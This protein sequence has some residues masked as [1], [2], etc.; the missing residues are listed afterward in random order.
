MFAQL[1]RRY[2][3][4]ERIRTDS[5]QLFASNALGRLSTLSVWWVR[6]AI[7]P[8]PIE[9]AHS[10][11]NG[12]HERMHNTLKAASARPPQAHLAAQQRCCDRFRQ[13]CNDERPHEALG[14]ATPPIC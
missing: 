5:G 2:R 14:D 7:R 6:L 13:R 4:P 12:R 3:L 11:Q 9:P 8:E 10:E 1:F